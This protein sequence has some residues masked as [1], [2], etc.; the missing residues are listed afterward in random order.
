MRVPLGFLTFGTQVDSEVGPVSIVAPAARF[1]KQERTFGPVP[2][3]GE[4]TDAIKS[5]FG[6]S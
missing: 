1:N 2:A 5:E 4:H 3:I 6:S